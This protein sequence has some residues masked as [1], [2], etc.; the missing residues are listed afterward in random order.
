MKVTILNGQTVSG[1]ADLQSGHLLGFALPAA[2]TGTA[3]TFKVSVDGV[4]YQDLYNPSNN[5]VSITVTQARS[6]AFTH[7]IAAQ[8]SNW[9]Y[10]K[11]V[12]GS[13]EGA[14]R[15]IMLWVR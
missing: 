11:I 2:F 10:L 15:D 12:S 5:A 4:T 13:A 3:I 14:D 9:R 8:V 6:Y 1:A 7:D